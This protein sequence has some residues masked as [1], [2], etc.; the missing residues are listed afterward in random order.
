MH[1]QSHAVCQKCDGHVTTGHPRSY[2]ERHAA[3]CVDVA[4][5]NW[6]LSRKPGTQ[7]FLLPGL[8]RLRVAPVSVPNRFGGSFT[9]RFTGFKTSSSSAVRQQLIQRER[10][11]GDRCLPSPIIRAGCHKS[12]GTGQ[13]GR[14]SVQ[15][16]DFRGCRRPS[17]N[18]PLHRI[19]FPY[20]S[21][22]QHFYKNIL[23]ASGRDR[24]ST[25]AATEESI[26]SWLRA[27]EEEASQ[28]DSRNIEWLASR[29]AWKVREAQDGELLNIADVQAR[30]FHEKQALPF[31]DK[32]VFGMLKVRRF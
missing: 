28:V 19:A 24:L 1:L 17:P 9:L 8:N 21:H 23:Q 26:D 16:E 3:A 25:E 12:H 32:P 5:W 11:V 22:V 27:L 2:Q 29:N 7:Q 4:P 15:L 6:S 14:H 18:R 30:A 31:M 20:S 13:K 10:S